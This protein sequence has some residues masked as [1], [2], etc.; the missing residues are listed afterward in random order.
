MNNKLIA[1]DLVDNSLYSTKNE[2]ITK[3]IYNFIQSLSPIGQNWNKLEYLINLSQNNF[4]RKLRQDYSVLSEDDIHIILL[5]RIGFNHSQIAEFINIQMHSLR[6]R[7][8][9]LK[10]KM[11][12]ECDSISDFIR[13]LYRS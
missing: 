11:K 7:R 2:E 1:I 9:R 4:A 8:S 3:E 6:I 5:L 13:K 10:K 12:V